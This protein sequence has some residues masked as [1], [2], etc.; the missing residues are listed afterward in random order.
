MPAIFGAVFRP[1]L[2]SLYKNI[3]VLR[4]PPLSSVLT[5]DRRVLQV[6]IMC[7]EEYNNN[8]RII[9]SMAVLNASSSYK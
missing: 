9:K 8:S 7:I 3:D 4:N 6:C 5:P 2:P 1:T